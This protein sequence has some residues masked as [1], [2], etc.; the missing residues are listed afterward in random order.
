MDLFGFGRKRPF[1]LGDGARFQAMA[2]NAPV[3]SV[4][5]PGGL[6]APKPVKTKNALT[7][8]LAAGSMVPGVGDAV[9]LLGDAAMY[10]SDPSSRTFMNG[11]LTAAGTLPLIPSASGIKAATRAAAGGETAKSNGYFYK[12]GQFLPSTDLPPG[13]FKIG[14]KKLTTKKAMIE[15]GVFETS[16]TPLHRSILEVAGGYSQMGPDGKLAV[17]D[18]VN[19]DYLGFTPDDPSPVSVKGLKSKTQR[20]LR[21]LIDAY[22][23]GD[24][25]LQVDIEE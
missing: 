19:W 9:G 22:N 23:R 20:S 8:L 10:A 25:W 3:G 7:G 14:G 15:P 1:A 24:R 5:A 18:G 16:P 13:T 2:D 6:L 21:E 17:K 4:G 12:G 11:L